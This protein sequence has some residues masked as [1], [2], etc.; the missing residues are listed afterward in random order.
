MSCCRVCHLSTFLLTNVTHLAVVKGNGGKGK[1]V[2]RTGEDFPLTPF[3]FFPEQISC[4]LISSL[5]REGK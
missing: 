3:H 5:I 2:K 1:K 4:T